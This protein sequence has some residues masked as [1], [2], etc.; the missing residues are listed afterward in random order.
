MPITAAEALAHVT[1][2]NKRRRTK[3]NPALR[4]AL[5]PIYIYS[6]YDK[7]LKW[8]TADC[9]SLGRFVIPRCEEGKEFSEPLV[10]NGLNPDE[11]DTGN[12]GNMAMNTVT[13][14]ELVSAI[15]G[16]ESPTPQLD[17]LTTNK[18]WFGV[19]SSM[20]NPPKK[21]EIAD[22]KKK[23]EQMMK[24]LLS[25][26]DKLAAAGK[27]ADIGIEERKAAVY[28]NQARDWSKP[29]MA[30]AV[31]PGCGDPVNP[32]AAVHAGQFGCGAVI[33]EAKVKAIKLKGY[34]H[35]WQAK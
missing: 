1:G 15:V 24:L 30:M 32:A 25:R 16:L 31:C 4:T 11:Y 6:I 3:F 28:L 14:E 26:G 21:S 23:L 2:M 17:L 22:A 7:P 27:V 33:D 19:F 29:P 10:I 9:G 8:R 5:P 34:E 35:L 12:D 13:G 20:S 18:Q